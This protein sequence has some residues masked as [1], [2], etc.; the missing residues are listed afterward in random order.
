MAEKGAAVEIMKE[1]NLRYGGE[2]QHGARGR[3][4]RDIG[5]AVERVRGASMIV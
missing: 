4:R 2:G 3:R 5:E 1:A